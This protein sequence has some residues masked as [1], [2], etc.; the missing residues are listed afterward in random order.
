M[1]KVIPC[2]YYITTSR[3]LLQFRRHRERAIKHA[4]CGRDFLFVPR[5]FGKSRYDAARRSPAER[6]ELS[7]QLEQSDVNRLC[8]PAVKQQG[9]ALRNDPAP[10]TPLLFLDYHVRRSA[11]REKNGRTIARWR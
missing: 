2:G 4:V 10:P 6:A 8:L 11:S 1:G 5:D 9:S 3:R 7:E